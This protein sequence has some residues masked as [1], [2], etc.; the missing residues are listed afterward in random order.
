MANP[1]N[2]F[3][4]ETFR[5]ISAPTQ[6]SDDAPSAESLAGLPP[7]QTSHE[8]I[9]RNGRH[10]LSG[11]L[12]PL[13][14]A[15]ASK[16]DKLGRQG[17]RR[18]WLP[19]VLGT[20]GLIVILGCLGVGAVITLNLLSLQNSLNSPQPTVDAFYSA[21]HTANYQA[22]YN[23]LSSN[24]QS[25]LTYPAFRAEFELTGSVASYQISGLQTQSNQASAAVKV[26]LARPDKST[27]QET[28]TVQL[29]LE[30]GNWKINRVDP[31][32]ARA[33]WPA[34]QRALTLDC[35]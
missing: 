3:D 27:V 30:N 11:P 12:A 17:G 14:V 15:S 31:S 25:H 2:P 18:T 23:Q 22:A 29:V 33:I 8:T 6:A 10:P 20:V 21:L 34:G 13:G 4:D 28:K 26:T 32:L 5:D 24:Y 16:L 35:C 19:F 1:L 7:P 9:G